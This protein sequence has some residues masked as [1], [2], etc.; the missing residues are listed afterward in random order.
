MHWHQ[1]FLPGIAVLMSHVASP[2]HWSSLVLF[3]GYCRNWEAGEAILTVEPRSSVIPVSHRLWDTSLMLV[4]TWHLSRLE[5]AVTFAAAAVHGH[6]CL[7][8]LLHMRHCLWTFSQLNCKGDACCWW[9]RH[10]VIRIP[11]G[12]GGARAYCWKD[13]FCTSVGCGETFK[14]Q[15]TCF[16]TGHM[17]SSCTKKIQF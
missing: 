16:S 3:S 2:F 12:N 9:G 7:P 10:T 15:S 4:F 5:S 6:R 1:H 11:C 13:L 8:V 14:Y 17:T